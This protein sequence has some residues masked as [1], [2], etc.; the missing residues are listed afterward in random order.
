MKPAVVIFV[1]SLFLAVGLPSLSGQEQAKSQENETGAKLEPDESQPQL[2]TSVSRRDPFKDLLGGTE[3]AE[4]S[5][6]GQGLQLAI[7]DLFL[8]AIVK[9]KGKLIALVST[10][11]Q[12]FPHKI[13]PGDK[14][15]DGYVLSISEA[16]VIFRKTSDRGVRLPKPKD[17]IKQISQ[18]ER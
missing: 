16:S 4:K 9:E 15:T 2:Y 6:A 14:F 10:G 17:V 13:Q 1:L 18:E 3:S 8:I 11:P 12:G 7:D 5:M